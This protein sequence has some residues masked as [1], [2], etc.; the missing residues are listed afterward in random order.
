MHKWN[1][2]LNVFPVFSPL[3][4]FDGAYCDPIF[5]SDDHSAPDI[6]ADGQNLFFSQLRPRML[7]ATELTL[8]TFRNLVSYVIR[9]VSQEEVV[10]IY[11]P[12]I[13]TPMQHMQPFRDWTSERF[14][15]IPVGTFGFTVTGH[16]T[17]SLLILT[18][19]PIPASTFCVYFN[20]VFDVLFHGC[21]CVSPPLSQLSDN[22]S[23]SLSESIVSSN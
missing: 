15:G 1:T 16:L 4:R 22:E 21:V 18:L 3:N 10:G 14:I 8:T 13:I 7:R 11:A 19:L 20:T 5:L 23:Q 6:G 2:Q 12:G 17:I 9:V